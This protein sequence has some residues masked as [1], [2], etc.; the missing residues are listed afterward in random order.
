MGLV[1]ISGYIQ[2]D[3]SCPSCMAPAFPVGRMGDVTIYE[4]RH[5]GQQHK[6]MLR[7]DTLVE[8]LAVND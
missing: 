8:E 5:C 2:D 3:S 7:L 6:R 4:C 1:R